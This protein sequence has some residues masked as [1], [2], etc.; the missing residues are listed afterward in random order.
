VEIHYDQ[1]LSSNV[2]SSPP[3]RIHSNQENGARRP[4]GVLECAIAEVDGLTE[5]AR[6]DPPTSR[7]DVA[8][9]SVTTFPLQ[10]LHTRATSPQTKFRY[11]IN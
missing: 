9:V 4:R 8:A 7:I 2:T 11:R 10:A 1:R 5:M 3:S 6:H